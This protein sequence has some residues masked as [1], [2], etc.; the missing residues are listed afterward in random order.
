IL[1]DIKEDSKNGR[2]YLPIEDLDKFDYT[3]EDLRQEIFDERFRKLMRFQTERARDYYSTARNLI[4]LVDEES[5]PA[6]W[7]MT[8]IYETILD[9]IVQR[10][11]NVF[12][13]RVRLSGRR[14]MSIL[15][16]AF[17]MRLKGKTG[18]SKNNDRA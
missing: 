14:K 7:A 18:F 17:A 8:A 4:P 10:D 11:F 5:R 15:L 16:K 1:R 6:L 2:V 9:T 3:T 13:D 12:R